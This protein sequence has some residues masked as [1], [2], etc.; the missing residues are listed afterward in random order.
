M[1]INTEHLFDSLVN[2][3]LA[4]AEKIITGNPSLLLS[5][6]IAGMTPLHIAVAKGWVDAIAMLIE[7]CAYKH[8]LA[9]MPAARDDKCFT[10]LYL[11]VYMGTF[12]DVMYLGL[13]AGSEK[14]AAAIDY[15]Q[16]C[17]IIVKILVRLGSAINSKSPDHL[18]ALSLARLMAATN[19]ERL[20]LELGAT[21]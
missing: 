4:E 16:T 11:A 9:E 21:D 10:P 14:E 1:N 7:H 6:N 2:L 12:A 18:S 15:F 5:R 3:N 8:V 13:P 19:I 17:I 20:L